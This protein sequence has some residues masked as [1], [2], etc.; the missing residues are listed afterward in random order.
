MAGRPNFFDWLN[1]A[2]HVLRLL[3]QILG[4]PNNDEETAKLKEAAEGQD[5]DLN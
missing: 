4:D 1:F 2:M 5:P 3:S